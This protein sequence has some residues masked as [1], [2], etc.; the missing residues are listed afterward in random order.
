M[1]K[2]TPLPLKYTRIVEGD[3]DTGKIKYLNS[4]TGLLL[5]NSPL[6]GLFKKTF[7][8]KVDHAK[9]AHIFD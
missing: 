2:Y 7:Y 8:E 1:I 9:A 3:E 4:E 5:T 6:L